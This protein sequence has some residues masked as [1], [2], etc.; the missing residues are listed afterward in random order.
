MKILM[1]KR[2][3]NE[4]YFL[5]HHQQ[6]VHDTKYEGFD[7]HTSTNN[8]TYKMNRQIHVHFETHPSLQSSPEPRIKNENSGERIRLSGSKRDISTE[9]DHESLIGPKDC[10]NQRAFVDS[11]RRKVDKD[12][13]ISGDP[14]PCSRSRSQYCEEPRVKKRRYQRRNSATA[15]MLCS[16]MQQ[17]SVP[18]Q[19][20]F[21]TQ[22]CLAKFIA[23]SVIC[24]P[25]EGSDFLLSNEN[26]NDACSSSELRVDR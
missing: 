17:C 3:R 22:D 14:T 24:G 19:H 18:N 23:N 10:E 1:S 15:A 4:S 9:V 21:L 7:E 5:Q 13:F 20:Q 8:K 11:K 2:R 26:K 12:D 16:Q 25:L 6:F